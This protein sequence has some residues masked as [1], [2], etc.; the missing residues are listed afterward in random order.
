MVD[1]AAEG[2]QGVPFE[3][4]VERGKIYELASAIKAD[5]PAFYS[6]TPVAP[7]TFLT[8]TF[9]WEERVPG[10]NPWSLV[11]MDQQR[12]MHAEQEYEFFGP[13]PAAGTKLT[14]RSTITRIFE[15]AGKRGG[16]MTFVVME[17]DF[18]DASG[19]LVAKAKMTGVEP[20]P[21]T[22]GGA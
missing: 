7:P 10:A 18:V 16:Q 20:A 17:T 22:E 14:C 4:E 8:T 21:A 1:K 13:P 12:G 15:K 19:K 3:M 2:K 9:F 6:A 11:K 5:H